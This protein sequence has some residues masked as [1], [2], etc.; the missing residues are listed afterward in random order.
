MAPTTK[1]P[2]PMHEERRRSVQYILGVGAKALANRRRKSA[3]A[4][5]PVSVA[6]DISEFTAIGLT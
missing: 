4:K 5:I 6:T 2:Q 1:A 3:S